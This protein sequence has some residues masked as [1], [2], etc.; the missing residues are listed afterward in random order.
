MTL[1]RRGFLG[2]GAMLAG[3]ALLGLAGEALAK[4]MVPHRPEAELAQA[5]EAFRTAMVKA[6]GRRLMALSS[7]N[8]RFGHSNGMVQSRAQF[9][10]S[11]VTKEEIFKS[12]RLSQH[13]NTV[14]GNTAVARHVFAADIL[15]KGKPLK[16]KLNCVEVWNKSGGQWRLVARQAFKPA[17]PV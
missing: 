4:P 16:V 11:V 1:S 12:I 15:F 17:A 6:D 10:R 8:L 7:P 14:V 13:R 5:I 9:V 2:A 3:S